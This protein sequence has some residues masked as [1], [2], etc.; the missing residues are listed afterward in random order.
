MLLRLV[1]YVIQASKVGYC[2]HNNASIADSRL[3]SL[4]DAL[5]EYQLA[6]K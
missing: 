4:L 1:F 6:S 3:R 2:L 5:L